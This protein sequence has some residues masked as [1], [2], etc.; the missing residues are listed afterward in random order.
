MHKSIANIVSC[1]LKEMSE[2]D[3]MSLPINRYLGYVRNIAVNTDTGIKRFPFE[4]CND[5]DSLCK[6]ARNDKI[7][8]IHKN[9]AGV[10]WVEANNELTIRKS[11]QGKHCLND[12]ET[13][14]RVVWIINHRRIQ[15]VTD[16]IC[17]H[18]YINNLI[19][20]YLICIRN[21]IGDCLTQCDITLDSIKTVEVVTLAPNMQTIFGQY[22]ESIF[23]AYTQ[24]PFEFGAIDVKLSISMCEQQILSFTLKEGILC[25]VPIKV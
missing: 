3:G 6:D 24:Y 20:S 11:A 4:G 2:E 17:L 8:I 19:A 13:T 5:T 21:N 18:D 23:Q 15:A 10:L 9:D 22:S 14:V 16:C 12:K 1:Y 25:P 7:G